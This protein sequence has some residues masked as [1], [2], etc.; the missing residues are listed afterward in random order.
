MTSLL[1]TNQSKDHNKWATFVT[2][3]NK[4]ITLPPRR[5]ILLGKAMSL[6]INEKLLSLTNTCSRKTR[7]EIFQNTLTILNIDFTTMIYQEQTEDDAYQE[8]DLNS[9]AQMMTALLGTNSERQ[10]LLTSHPLPPLQNLPFHPLI[11]HTRH[12]R[13]PLSFSFSTKPLPIPGQRK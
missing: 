12:K 10:T 2:P 3:Q 4:A 1:W 13:H 6:D 5:Y 8:M 7:E 9:F 11:T